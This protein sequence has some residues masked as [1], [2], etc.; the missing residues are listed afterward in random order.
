[1]LSHQKDLKCELLSALS[2]CEGI[3]QGCVH[4]LD[5]CGEANVGASDRLIRILLSFAEKQ[6]GNVFPLIS[7]TGIHISFCSWASAICT[8]YINSRIVL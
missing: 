1:M 4:V 7:V 8:L 6:R 2:G 5:A 3:Y